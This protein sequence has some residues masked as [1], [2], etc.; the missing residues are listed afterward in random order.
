MTNESR[1]LRAQVH[2]IIFE[3][4]TPAGKAFDVA[5]LVLIILSVIAVMLE[6]TT[7]VAERYGQ[8]LRTFEWV[9]TFLFTIEYLL[10]LYCVGKPAI[11]ARSFFGIVDLLAILPSYLSLVI[12]GA[13]SLL[14]IRAL[15]LLRVF[16]VLKLAHFVGEARELRA[17]LR[18]SARKI[19]VFLGTVLTIVIIVGSLMYLIEGE[20]HGFTSIPVSIYWAIVTMTTVGYGDIA[21]QTALGKILASAIMIMG[22]GIIAVPTGIVSVELAG[23]SRKKIT[24]QAC[25]E[26]AAGG[27]DLDAVHCKYCGA[28][29]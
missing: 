4:D 20:D 25:P 11:Y 27:H 28:K 10:R 15:R 1:S 29:I 16:R 17:A 26:C 19:I 5:L 8:W 18:A 24:T 6:S 23:V 22:Y 9:V 21:P 13:Q 14:V 12:P 2:E 7:S 3:A